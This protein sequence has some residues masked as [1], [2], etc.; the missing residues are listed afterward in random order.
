MAR[1]L[2]LIVIALI[3]IA[4]AWLAIGREAKLRIKQRRWADFT[5][6]ALIFT[7]VALLTMTA[8]RALVFTTG[9]FDAAEQALQ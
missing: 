4:I 5:V 7:I 3:A 8:L 6:D 2:T 9:A 1:T